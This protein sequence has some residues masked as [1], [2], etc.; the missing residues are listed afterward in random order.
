MKPASAGFFLVRR[1]R[2]APPVA[3]APNRRHGF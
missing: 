3:G 1:H 2:A